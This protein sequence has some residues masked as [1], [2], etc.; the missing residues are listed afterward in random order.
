MSPTLA[1]LATALRAEELL[2]WLDAVEATGVSQADRDYLRR[3]IEHDR[4]SWSELPASMASCL[5]A[6]TLGVAGLEGLRSAWLAEVE[7]ADTPW[8]R[9]LHPLPLQPGLLQTLRSGGAVEVGGVRRLTFSDEETVTLELQGQR[10]HWAWREDEVR[11]EQV[12]VPP[13]AAFPRFE[14]QGGGAV[15]MHVD[16]VAEPIRLPCPDEANPSAQMGRDGRTIIVHGS[17]DEGGGFVWFLKEGGLEVE[18]TLETPRGVMSVHESVDGGVVLAMTYAGVV[19]WVG[20]ERLLLPIKGDHVALSPSGE[21]VAVRT[22][23]VI[24]MWSIRETPSGEPDGPCFPARFDAAGVR[25]LRGTTLYDAASGAAIATL[26]AEFG[27]YFEGGPAFPWFHLGNDYVIN[28]HSTLQVWRAVDGEP[29]KAPR[30]RFPHWDRLAHADSGRCFA[31]LRMSATDVQ[32][33][34]VPSGEVVAQVAFDLEHPTTL[35]LSPSGRRVAVAQGADIEVRTWTGELV[36]RTRH[37][38]SDGDGTRR[39][40]VFDRS[41]QFADED[42]VVSHVKA[43]GWRLFRLVEGTSDPVGEPPVGSRRRAPGW[44]VSV[45]GDATVFEHEPTGTRIA[46]PV[47]GEWVV[48]PSRPL[49]ACDGAH[50]ELLGARVPESSRNVCEVSTDRE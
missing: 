23:G 11:L 8:V 16:G 20:D 48:H 46:L 27:R 24:Q 9:S 18:R 26:A 21:R 25:L 40:R 44:K 28:S 43:D 12:E 49:L 38:V 5:L 10:V 4:R 37:P 32:L 2:R 50:V 13:A 35:A 7:A 17:H 31:A 19:C 36:L 41:L 39:P 3:T 45:A 1:A 33:H 15:V 34:A 22:R 6:R 14:Y 29:L 47:G 42:H 30:M